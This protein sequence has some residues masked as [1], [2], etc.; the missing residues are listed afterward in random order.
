M[1]TKSPKRGP[2][3]A[4]GLRRAVSL[5]QF[6]GSLVPIGRIHLDILEKAVDF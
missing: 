2:G 1:S 4:R 6:L 5:L 3:A